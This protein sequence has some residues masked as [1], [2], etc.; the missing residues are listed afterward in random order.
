MFKIEHANHKLILQVDHPKTMGPIEALRR[1]I[2]KWYFILKNKEKINDDGGIKT[3]ALC[4]LYFS[5]NCRGCPVKKATGQIQCYGSPYAVMENYTNTMGIEDES[6][7][8]VEI[9]VRAEIQ[10]LEELLKK[11][12][13]KKV[14]QLL[15]A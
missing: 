10:F 7:E 15:K 6:F 11:E 12:S 13:N 2:A 1:S 14:K 3:C 9:P 8:H 4:S 5:N